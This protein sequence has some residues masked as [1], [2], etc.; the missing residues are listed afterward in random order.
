M[1]LVVQLAVPGT[2]PASQ[3]DELIAS[4]GDVNLSVYR[5]DRPEQIVTHCSRV[6]SNR[7]CRREY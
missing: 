2:G 1:I 5:A 4:T 7:V 3:G 6:R